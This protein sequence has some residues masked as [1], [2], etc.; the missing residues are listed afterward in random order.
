MATVIV[1]NGTHTTTAPCGC[2]A[3]MGLSCLERPRFFPSQLLTD[4][5]LG[6]SL[7]YVT[8]KNRLH[9]RYLHGVGVV[10]GLEVVCNDCAGFVTVKQGYAIDP[11][12]NDIVVCADQAV[13]VMKCIQQ[14]QDAQRVAQ[15]SGCDPYVPQND[16]Q[17][18]EGEQQWCLVIDYQ[19]KQARPITTLRT[20]TSQASGCSC[21]G[22]CGGSGGCGCGGG[23]AG[24]NC[25][26]SASSA[27][28]VAPTAL[29]TRPTMSVSSTSAV[30]CEPTRVL[31]QFKLECIPGAVCNPLNEI[32]DTMLGHLIACFK[33][34]TV[35]GKAYLQTND[36][37][38]LYAIFFGTALPSETPAQAVHDACC[39][40][41]QLVIALYQKDPHKVRCTALQVVDQVSCPQPDPGEDVDA[42]VKRTQ[43]SL[44][45]LERYGFDYLVDCFCSALMPTCAPDPQDDRLVLACLTIK[46]GNII[47]ICDFHCR[48]YA[49]SFPALRYW[50]SVMP[51]IGYIVDLICCNDN[52]MK[53]L[54]GLLECIDPKQTWVS[55]IATGNFRAVREVIGSV[56]NVGRVPWCRTL[57]NFVAPSGRTFMVSSVNGLETAAAMKALSA[58]QI[59]GVEVPVASADAVPPLAALSRWPLA[60]AGEAVAVYTFDGFVVGTGAAGASEVLAAKNAEIASI[61]DR[62]DALTARLNA[63]PNA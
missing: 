59:T 5:E 16:P 37:P 2:P 4:R 51:V 52:R 32:S 23:Q 3:C 49:G 38:I 45:T 18:G 28:T 25:N 17:C 44:T 36:I 43:D 31:E 39:R 12:G 1:K 13:D 11:C 15:K 58:Q 9:N 40:L 50:T 22:T 7:D 60:A 62:L 21:G 34:L 48:R 29:A 8:A 26:G 6:G 19:E 42:Y 41:R 61:H 54:V 20:T 14:C 33:T 57:G 24:C 53:G 63:I 30:A 46:D 10:C 56:G 27:W 35:Y 47:R 55:S